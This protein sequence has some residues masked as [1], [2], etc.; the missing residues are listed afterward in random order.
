RDSWVTE[1]VTVLRR[2]P[3]AEVETEPDVVRLKPNP[4]N[5][6]ACRPRES[7]RPLAFGPLFTLA[8]EVLQWAAVG[9]RTESANRSFRNPFS[10]ISLDFPPFGPKRRSLSLPT[11]KANRGSSQT[12]PGVSLWARSFTS[13][14]S[15]TISAVPTFN[16]CFLNSATFKAPRS[17]PIGRQA[18]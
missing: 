18:A 6:S 16:S 5:L 11:R 3:L 1:D 4:L 14:T 9:N 10:S 7:L 8:V 13:V 17:S 15:A 2:R 12:H